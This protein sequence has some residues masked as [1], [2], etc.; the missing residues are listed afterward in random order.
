MGSFGPGTGGG[1]GATTFADLTDTNLSSPAN[2]DFLARVAGQWANRNVSQSRSLLDV[3]SNADLTSGLAGK[4]NT[5]HTHTAS[6]ITD[7]A[8]AVASELGTAWDALATN[9]LPKVNAAGALVASGLNDDGTLLA[10]NRYLIALTASGGFPSAIYGL[11]RASTGALGLSSNNSTQGFQFSV[12]SSILAQIGA[13]GMGI[14]LGGLPTLSALDVQSTSGAQWAARYSATQFLRAAVEPSYATLETSG[15]ELLRLK[16]YRLQFQDAS[17]NTILDSFSDG[18]SSRWLWQFDAAGWSQMVF[19]FLDALHLDVG[20][21]RRIS[22]GS[23]GLSFFGASESGQ[24]VVP[25]GSSVDDVITALQTFG[26]FLQ[27]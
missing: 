22:I 3:P 7:F 10:V 9:S 16:S 24:I 6:Q 15:S 1:G 20:G 8:S 21:A 13:A 27:S 2:D 5:S 12:N 19:N 18:G 17:A 25:T 14:G 4:A 11:Y 23:T 26:L